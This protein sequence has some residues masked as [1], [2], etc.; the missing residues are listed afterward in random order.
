MFYQQVMIEYFQSKLLN[1][2]NLDNVVVLRSNYQILVQML[3]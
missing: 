1:E 2:R 3:K